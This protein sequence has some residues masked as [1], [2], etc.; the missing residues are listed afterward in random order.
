M[1]SFLDAVEAEDLD[2]LRPLVPELLKQFL[3]LSQEVGLGCGVYTWVC[4]CWGRGSK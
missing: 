2:A 3:H 4:G 1:R